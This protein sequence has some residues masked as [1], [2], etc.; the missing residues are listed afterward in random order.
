MSCIGKGNIVLSVTTLPS[1]ISKIGVMD[2]RH[3]KTR[4]HSE[5]LDTEA[6]GD[7]HSNVLTNTELF[8]L[9]N[10]GDKREIRKHQKA[11]RSI[12]AAFCIGHFCL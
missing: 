5:R 12:Y 11:R 3:T 2:F 7:C 4:T 6:D 9:K 1:R 8:A 10:K